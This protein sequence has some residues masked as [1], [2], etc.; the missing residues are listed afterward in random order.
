[1]SSH[2][3]VTKRRVPSSTTRARARAR[4]AVAVDVRDARGLEPEAPL[5]RRH[6]TRAGRRR[7]L[8]TEAERAVPDARRRRGVER[9]GSVTVSVPSITTF[10]R[11]MDRTA[12]AP[13]DVALKLRH[14][15]VAEPGPATTGEL[16]GQPC[17]V[18]RPPARPARRARRRASHGRRRPSPAWLHL[19][20]RS[21]P[22][23]RSPGIR[24]RTTGRPR[25]EAPPAGRRRTGHRSRLVGSSKLALRGLMRERSAISSRRRSRARRRER[26]GS[27]ACA[28]GRRRR[29]RRRSGT[30]GLA[31]R[32]EELRQTGV[33]EVA[34]VAR[35][36]A[37]RRR[38]RRARRPDG[39]TEPDDVEAGLTA[40]PPADA[41]GATTGAV[42]SVPHV[43]RP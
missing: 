25:A 16:R 1:M 26:S 32:G 41:P 42:H 9:C 23:G 17:A 30:G 18:E 2:P 33:Q 6:P 8:G 43:A 24:L 11:S 7:N 4:R 5:Q 31:R 35:P 3:A 36:V 39:G 38:R 37:R 29:R 19:P 14:L 21:V 28:A 34:V 12:L 22:S 15:H 20:R 13:H 40:T 27:F 10:G